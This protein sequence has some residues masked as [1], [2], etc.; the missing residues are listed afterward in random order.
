MISPKEKGLYLTLNIKFKLFH[1]S[2]HQK[3]PSLEV[4]NKTLK[5]TNGTD[6]TIKSFDL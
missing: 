5:T 1:S 4:R 2:E 3:R 6:E